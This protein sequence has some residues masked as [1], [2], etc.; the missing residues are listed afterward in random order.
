M[1]R[2]IVGNY[3]ETFS[4][5][6]LIYRESIAFHHLLKDNADLAKDEA[7][8]GLIATG[9]LYLLLKSPQIKECV[10]KEIEYY[11]GSRALKK[12]KRGKRSYGELE[13]KLETL[14]L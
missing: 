7:L 11:K 13:R 14:D 1:Y 9:V 3:P 6:H 12:F 4:L 2:A 8:S 10:K 5:T